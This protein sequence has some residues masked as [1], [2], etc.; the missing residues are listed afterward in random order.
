MRRRIT[1]RIVR[2]AAE[3]SRHHDIADVARILHITPYV[4]GLIAKY[5]DRVIRRRQLS[6]CQREA[7]RRAPPH[8]SNRQLA[9][10]FDLTEGYVR[11]LRRSHPKGPT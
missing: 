11:T 1:R 7:I 4:A 8:I 3:L 10:R 5:R 6:P 9:R 2:M